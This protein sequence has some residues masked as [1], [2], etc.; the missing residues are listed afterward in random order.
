MNITEYSHS[1]TFW[2]D[3]QAVILKH[4]LEAEL[5]YLNARNNIGAEQGFFGAAIKDGDNTL[6]AIQTPP[7][8]MIFFTC[9]GNPEPLA[10]RMAEHLIKTEKVSSVINGN[11]ASM[12]AVRDA[13]AELGIPYRAGRRLLQR[14]CEKLID[15]ETLDLPL[16]NANEVAYD[17]TE[18]YRNFLEECHAIYDPGKVRQDIDKM[19]QNNDLYVLVD[20]GAVVTMGRLQRMIPGARAVAVIYTPPKYRGRKYST[21]CTK[22]LTRLIFRDGYDYAYLY[23]EADNPVS[24]R[25]YE[26]LGYEV[27]N[28]FIEF[29]RK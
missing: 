23:A 28:E 18:D 4:I 7:F 9:G 3:N 25:V 29:H 21:C 6:L 24:N 15:V 11:L 17:F 5:V 14:K 16:V 19:L 27:A 13:F 22:Q 20:H 26:K 8:P 10:R 1:E 12:Q 2:T